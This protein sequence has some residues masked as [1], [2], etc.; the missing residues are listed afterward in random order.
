VIRFTK[1]PL[2]LFLA[3]V[4]L[5]SQSHV[6]LAKFVA[7]THPMIRTNTA[8][9]HVSWRT[10]EIKPPPNAPKIHLYQKLNPVWWLKNSDDPKPPAWY[11]PGEKHR[12]FKWSFR[13]P[14]HNF[15]FYI[16]GVADKKFSRS[17]RFPDKNSDPRGGWDFEAARYKFIWLPFVSYHRPKFDFYFGWRNRGNFGIKVNINPKKGTRISLPPLRTD[18]EEDM[19]IEDGNSAPQK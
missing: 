12:R 18:D 2:A 4:F 6:A 11:R 8:K 14:L 17:G 9:S 3:G 16:I 7:E 15:D 10:V 1:L 5:L 13:N 19:K